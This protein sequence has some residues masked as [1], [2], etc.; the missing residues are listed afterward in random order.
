MGVE[1]ATLVILVCCLLL[2][3][4]AYVRVA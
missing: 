2:C 4:V 1:A 3:W